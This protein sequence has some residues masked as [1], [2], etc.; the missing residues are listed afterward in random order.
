MNDPNASDAITKTDEPAR[1]A[2]CLHPFYSG[3]VQTM[4]ECGVRGLR[5][6]ALWYAPGVGVALGS[7]AQEPSTARLERIESVPLE[8]ALLAYR[9]T[10]DAT[11]ASTREQVVAEPPNAGTGAI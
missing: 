5:D 3:E 4:P 2:L 1:G 8:G 6:C 10:R 9:S 11:R 7:T